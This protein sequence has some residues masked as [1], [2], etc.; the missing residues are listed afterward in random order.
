MWN[1]NFIVRVLKQ[2]IFWLISKIWPKGTSKFDIDF[3]SKCIKKFQFS[4][5]TANFIYIR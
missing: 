3:I 1:M 5:L 2:S 4:D